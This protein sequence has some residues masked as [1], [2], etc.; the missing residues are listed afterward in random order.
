MKATDI[1]LQTTTAMTLANLVKREDEFDLLKSDNRVMDFM[2]QSFSPSITSSYGTEFSKEEIVMGLRRL[3][4]NDDNKLTIGQ[5]PKVLEKLCKIVEK[6]NPKKKSVLVDHALG[7]LYN[8]AFK[9]ENRPLLKQFPGLV[10]KLKGLAESPEFDISKES[11]GILYLLS[12]FSLDRKEPGGDT[13]SSPSS[14]SPSSNKFDVMLSYNWV[15]IIFLSLF[16]NFC[17]LSNIF[18]FVLF[19]PQNEQSKAV[20]LKDYLRKRGL[21]V[22]I[23]LEQMGGSTLESMAFAIDNSALILICFSQRYKESPNCRM[24]A[25]YTLQQK[26]NLIPLKFQDQYSPDGWLGMTIGTK[27]WFDFSK[28]EL[29]DKSGEGLVREIERKGVSLLGSPSSGE[30]LLQASA[31]AAAPATQGPETWKTKEI[32]EWLEKISLSSL[33]EPFQREAVNGE[34]L[35]QLRHLESK[36]PEFFFKVLKEEF[37]L[38]KFGDRLRF[39]R[40]LSKLFP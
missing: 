29:F 5:N 39:A 13:S 23:D 22:W 18:F 36:S 9:E 7:T 27:L 24:E 30:L 1:D 10:D 8:L 33:N 3:S 31:P 16:F 21:K 19:P 34:G 12:E 32:T 37:G 11:K 15:S 6:A 4:V 17:F 25:E 40:E 26:K 35:E 14:S 38:E 20:K 2:L 28:L